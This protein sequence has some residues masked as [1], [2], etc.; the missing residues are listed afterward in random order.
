MAYVEAHIGV[1]Q[2]DQPSLTRGRSRYVGPYF[3][4]GAKRRDGAAL[5]NPTADYED[6]YRCDY[7]RDPEYGG[8]TATERA[9][10]QHPS[11]RLGD[12][13]RCETEVRV[14]REALV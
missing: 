10:P 3:L 7:H 4:E 6:A 5:D 12:R 11:R 9:R 2:Q 14:C 8:R 1:Y 13:C